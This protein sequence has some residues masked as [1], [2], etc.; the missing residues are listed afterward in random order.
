MDTVRSLVVAASSGALQT[1]DSD[2]GID[3]S[4]CNTVSGTLNSSQSVTPAEIGIG[5]SNSDAP[6]VAHDLSADADANDDAANDDSLCTENDSVSGVDGDLDCGISSEHTDDPDPDATDGV[7][8][9]DDQPLA[10]FHMNVRQAHELATVGD[11]TTATTIMLDN[12]RLFQQRLQL[13]ERG[14]MASKEEKQRQ[15]EEIVIMESSSVSSETGSWES[16]FPQRTPTVSGAD[17][18]IGSASTNQTQAPLLPPHSPPPPPSKCTDI[19]L[20]DF[21]FTSKSSATTATSACFIDASSL[22]DDTEL[23]ASNETLGPQLPSVGCRGPKPDADSSSSAPTDL[24]SPNLSDEQKLLH[25]VG[26]NDVQSPQLV[27]QSTADGGAYADIKDQFASGPSIASSLVSVDVTT[28]AAG[29]SSDISI[30]TAESAAE[31]QQRHRQDLERKQG[32]FLFCNSIQH[33]S[34]HVLNPIARIGGVG[35][36]RDEQRTDDVMSS[37]ISLPSMYSTGSAD[38]ATPASLD[39][40][41]AAP[42]SQP[43]SGFYPDTPHNSIMHIEHVAPVPIASTV[44]AASD[45]DRR[46]EGRTEGPAEI[47]TVYQRPFDSPS[48]RRKTETCPILSGGLQTEDLQD[49]STTAVRSLRDSSLSS[50]LNSWVV[51]MSDCR[52]P[53]QDRLRMDAVHSLDT[54]SSGTSGA[55]FFVDISDGDGASSLPPNMSTVAGPQQRRHGEATVGG[56][57]TATAEKKNIFSMFI[58]FGDKK[59]VARR[60]PTSFTSR[61]SMSM[62]RQ[63]SEGSAAVSA[64]TSETAD[65]SAKQTPVVV[66]RN[67]PATRPRNADPHNRYSWNEPKSKRTPSAPHRRI[68]YTSS[69]SMPN[70]SESHGHSDSGSGIMSILDKIPLISKT[71]SMVADSPQSP[72]DDLTSASCTKSMSLYSNN[73]DRSGMLSS[74]EEARLAGQP[75]ADGIAQAPLRKRRQ[76]VE[77]NETFDKSSRSSLPEEHLSTDDTSPITDTDDVTFQNELDEDPLLDMMLL[78]TA[79]AETDQ[80]ASATIMQPAESTVGPSH[81]MESLQAIMERQQKL[82]LETVTEEPT[83]TTAFVKLSDMDKPALKFELHSA[84]AA[85]DLSKSIGMA[86]SRIERLFGDGCRLPRSVVGR[87]AIHPMSRSTGE[88]AKM[89]ILV[90]N[91]IIIITANRVYHHIFRQ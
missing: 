23:C 28:A 68:E 63:H 54:R 19:R 33:F 74:T 39:T 26:P 6:S 66:R 82:L 35:F 36:H 86:T 50:S 37:E 56:E 64:D 3:A 22:M 78:Q 52:S 18:T 81:T 4:C 16:V 41:V 75:N 62:L 38:L 31:L 80:P 13:R 32:H 21:Q 49:E 65:V 25:R 40:F 53:K 1:A 83:N 34:G 57:T 79:A 87:S 44:S 85:A 43:E 72:F 11:A 69:L 58:D 45:G 7:D 90:C 14:R 8:V 5:S 12:N 91:N 73:S 46:K 89:Y 47:T 30:S 61:L 29:S 20:P 15:N 51:D 84:E 88:Y 76:D 48:V 10:V 59:P 9:D 71:S 67:L 70:G 60:D 2:S 17:A 77:I 55:R 27:S 42:Y 24:H